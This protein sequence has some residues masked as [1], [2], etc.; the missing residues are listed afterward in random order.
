MVVSRPLGPLIG[1]GWL[2][3]DIRILTLYR[4]LV[5]LEAPIRRVVWPVLI[6]YRSL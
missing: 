3:L 6:D 1:Y 5:I 4:Y 2:P